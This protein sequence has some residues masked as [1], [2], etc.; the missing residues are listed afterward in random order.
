MRL[1]IVH[2]SQLAALVSIFVL[3]ALC[4]AAGL[5]QPSSPANADGVKLPILMY[6]QV[7]KTP[8]LLGAYVVSPEE[9]EN[10]F[11]YLKEKG[12]TAVSAQEVIDFVDNGVA[13]PEKPIMITFD[14]GQLSFYEYVL[15]LLEEYD[16]CAV[17]SV[18]GSYTDVYTENQDRHVAYAYLNWQDLCHL[19]ES[20][21]VDLGN[22][23]YNLHQ[24]GKRR[25]SMQRKGESDAEYQAM[26]KADLQKMQAVMAE[27]G[28]KVPL[29]YTYPFGFI[30]KSS[31]V[32]IEEVGFRMSLGCAEGVNLLYGDPLCLFELKRYNRPHGKSARAILEGT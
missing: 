11:K 29:C 12:Y 5:G 4:L 26:L 16:L 30:S 9:L 28:L 21:R 6:H 19:E 1:Y 17:L 3:L 13:L 31:R 27:H 32:V 8:G 14:D 7:L 24:N 10:D 22:H 15:P 18:V 20:G 25:G 2:R 23:T